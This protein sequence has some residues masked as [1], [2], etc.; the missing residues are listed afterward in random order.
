M[1]F[2]MHGDGQTDVIY[3]R[4]QTFVVGLSKSVA[5]YTKKQT[6]ECQ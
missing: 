6:V 5:W 3:G 1:K 2:K 4:Q